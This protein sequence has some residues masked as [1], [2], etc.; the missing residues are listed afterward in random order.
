[1]NLNLNNIKVVENESFILTIFNILF[2][3]L[4][5]VGILYVFNN[6]LFV[7]SD[8]IKIILLSGAITAPLILINTLVMVILLIEKNKDSSLFIP[9]SFGIFL[10]GLLLYGIIGVHYI[11]DKPFRHGV[12]FII[13][14]EAIL[15]VSAYVKLRKAKKSS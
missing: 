3:V 5:G 11:F 15:L 12:Y 7:N 13:I 2:L 10:S 4:P 9:F 8:W 14:V 1:M 6:A